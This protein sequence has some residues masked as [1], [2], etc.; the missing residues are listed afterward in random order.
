M[1]GKAPKVPSQYTRNK[2]KR[3]AALQ[4]GREVMS[5]NE[6]YVSSSRVD[7]HSKYYNRSAPDS[8]DA[9]LELTDVDSLSRKAQSLLVCCGNSFNQYLLG[10]RPF[11]RGLRCYLWT[12]KCREAACSLS[13]VVVGDLI[14]AFSA[15]KGRGPRWLSTLWLFVS[16]PQ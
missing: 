10:Y 13:C 12:N 1:L 16:V 4:W 11:G 3:A 9:L 14:S 7:T 6:P 15:P 2:E 5:G 8:S